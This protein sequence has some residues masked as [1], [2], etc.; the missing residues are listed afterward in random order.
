MATPVIVWTD[1]V[2]RLV[3]LIEGGAPPQYRL[4][5]KEG[6]LDAMGKPHWRPI[7]ITPQLFNTILQS[8]IAWAPVQLNPDDQW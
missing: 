3:Q 5:V 1:H 7:Q 2:H 4:E 8:V 6:G